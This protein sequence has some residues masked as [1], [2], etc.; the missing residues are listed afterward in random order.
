MKTIRVLILAVVAVCCAEA[1]SVY[2]SLTEATL[3]S[4]GLTDCPTPDH[5]DCEGGIASALALVRN[6]TAAPHFETHFVI[7]E[8]DRQAPFVQ[9]HPLDWGV[10]TMLFDY[11]GLPI[12][13]VRPSLFT[14]RRDIVPLTNG[15]VRPVLANV[16]ISAN[17]GFHGIAAPYHVDAATGVAFIAIANSAQPNS[18]DSVETT[19]WSTLAARRDPRTMAVVVGYDDLTTTADF[20]AAV[21]RYIAANDEHNRMSMPDVVLSYREDLTPAL[22]VNRTTWMGSIGTSSSRLSSVRVTYTVLTAP[23]SAQTR[24]NVRAVVSAISAPNDVS[25]EPI[26][27]GMRDATYYTHQARLK[28][29]ADIAAANDPVVG[30]AAAAMP[31]VRT[32]PFRMCMA[33]ECPLGNLWTDSY[34]FPY[35][36]ELA[37]TGSGGIRGPGWPAGLIRVSDIWGTL[38]FANT[39]CRGR[40]AGVTIWEMVNA[41]LTLATFEGV[42]TPTGDRLLQMSGLRVRFNYGLPV[43]A[44]VASVEVLDRATGT[45]APLERLRTYSFAADSFFCAA[46]S[47]F[48]EFVQRRQY[49]GETYEIGDLLVQANLASYLTA[50]SPYTPVATGNRIINDTTATSAE[51]MNA[52]LLQTQESCPTDTYWEAAIY[53]CVACPD[54]T[55]APA[56]GARSCQPAAASDKTTVIALAVVLPLLVVIAVIAVAIGMKRQSDLSASVRDV[57]N[58][59]REGTITIMFTDIQDSTKLW[60]TC[61]MAMSVALDTHHRVIREAIQRNKGYE[62]KT[63]G[64]SF[65]IAAGSV[66]AAIRIAMD[67]QRGVFEAAMPKC[68]DKVY[69]ANT[70][71][72]LFA[73]EDDP[74]T[75]TKPQAGDCWHGLRVRIGFTSGE[76]SVTFDE[77]TKGYDYYG[78][79]VNVAARTEA[80]AR[81]GQ[82]VATETC[83]KEA[84]TMGDVTM[85]DLGR[86]EMK[87]VPE[88]VACVEV[89]PSELSAARAALFDAELARDEGG[90]LAHE[91][92]GSTMM[93][94]GEEDPAVQEHAFFISALFRAIPVS[95]RAP[96]TEKFTSAWRIQSKDMHP[97]DIAYALAQRVHKAVARERRRVERNLGGSSNS[98]NV[99]HTPSQVSAPAARRSSVQVSANVGKML[100]G[101][102]RAD[103]NSGKYRDDSNADCALPHSPAERLAAPE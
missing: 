15:T 86:F 100:S 39:L 98:V 58:A 11:F 91:D 37:F 81:G 5:E 8:F 57:A 23:T 74:D 103:S 25:I 92:S 40:L 16:D 90:H 20:V 89:A 96:L 62:V 73:I 68:I 51:V 69:A 34:R 75:T 72:E 63:A 29:E 46:F 47:P 65:M 45:Y 10:N 71:D 54:G 79:P 28:Q 53:T 83:L 99:G 76:P 21:G 14:T 101:S 50:N 22:D 64:D 56:G 12:M 88:P 77:V 85:R 78:P 30:T 52:V 60:S 61:P 42:S 4:G 13:T 38:P 49:E 19:V 93:D 27:M 6:R 41:S 70:E 35:G 18:I 48:A 102:L 82:V 44:R 33:G 66:D 95:K 24:R 2:V 59:P 55:R 32:G 17:N 87:G 94:D 80:I 1:V 7:C 26:D 43:H 3:L 97:D 84:S 9:M 31:F 36:D 67:I